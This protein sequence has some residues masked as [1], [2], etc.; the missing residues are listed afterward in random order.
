VISDSVFVDNKVSLALHVFG[1]P[2]V[3]H[4][5]KDNMITV[6]NSL[7]IGQSTNFDCVTDK[8]IPYHASKYMWRRSPR[9][10]GGKLQIIDSLK[11]V[12]FENIL[13]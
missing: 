6:Q 4:R 7:L 10:P 5:T 11:N 2:A 12:F 8:K 9:P 3:S 13:L 1:P